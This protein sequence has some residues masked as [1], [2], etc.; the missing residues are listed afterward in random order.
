M[1]LT[2]KLWH[3][4]WHD[5]AL[6]L[7]RNVSDKCGTNIRQWACEGH[8]H[9]MQVFHFF[10]YLPI[11]LYR[12]AAVESF[13]TGEWVVVAVIKCVYFS[14]APHS[15]PSSAILSSSLTR[16][17]DAAVCWK[18]SFM[19]TPRLY[20]SKT[21]FKQ[22]PPYVRFESLSL[23]FLLALFEVSNA[24]VHID[25]YLALSNPFCNLDIS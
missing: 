13:L 23:S 4:I 5:S 6:S 20:L 22:L 3:K 8:K 21:S 11:I 15:Y 9:L 16:L 25:L 18:C 17:H 2:R 7:H 12:S 14:P 24:I 10:H 19:A 1:G